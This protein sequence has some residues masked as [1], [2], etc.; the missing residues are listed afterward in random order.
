MASQIPIARK[1]CANWDRG[2]CLGCMFK[3]VDGEL[4][5]NL[6][7]K[8]AGRPCVVDDGCRYFEKIVLKG[9]ICT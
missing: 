2:I 8:F 3:R 7:K 5:M 9:N 4:F 6:D 1:Y